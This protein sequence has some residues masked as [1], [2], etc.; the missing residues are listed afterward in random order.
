MQVIGFNFTNI[1]AKKEQEVKSSNIALNISFPNIEK[2]KL[3]L[4]KDKET[5]KTEFDFS[6]VYQ[7]QE[8]NE[9]SKKE[10]ETKPE[11]ELLF[12]GSIL[13][14]TSD[15]ESRDILKAWKK[16]KEI[17]PQLRIFLTNLVLKKCSAH[18][19]NL[20]EELNLP[21]HIKVPMAAFRSNNQ[22]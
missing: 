8:S 9:K 14:L 1:S 4:L 16:N 20:Q 10:K 3:D 2:E 17:E 7:N 18:A 6:I 19:L 5:L 12:Q 21:S 13:I 22:K 11:A 15:E